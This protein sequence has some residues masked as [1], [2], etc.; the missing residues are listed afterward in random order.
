[1][2]TLQQPEAY[3]RHADRLFDNAGQFVREDTRVFFHAFIPAFAGWIDAQ[4][5]RQAI[6][7]RE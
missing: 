1:M 6:M 2:P 4:S 5:T 7:M 3:V